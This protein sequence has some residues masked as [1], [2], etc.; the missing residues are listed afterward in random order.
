MNYSSGYPMLNGPIKA[1]INGAADTIKFTAWDKIK[2]A[3]AKLDL[4]KLTEEKKTP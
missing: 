2:T 4:N 3:S 1:L